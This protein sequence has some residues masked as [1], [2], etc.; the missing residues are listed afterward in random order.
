VRTENVGQGAGAP[1]Y[2]SKWLWYGIACVAYV[3][4]LMSKQMLVTL[5]FVLLLIDWWPLKRAS[6]AGNPAES[7]ELAASE[8]PAQSLRRR[9]RRGGG[10][11]QP[12]DSEVLAPACTFGA[13]TW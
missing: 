13:T 3:A 11:M 7:K 4:S 2:S 10:G 6:G 12:S 5:P 8:Q 1:R 9:R